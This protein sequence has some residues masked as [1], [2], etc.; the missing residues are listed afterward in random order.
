MA[1]HEIGASIKLEGENKFRNAMKSAENAIKALN[2]E[3]K[4]AKAQF[5]AT[6]D[7][8]AYAAEK[9]R[10]LKEKIEEQKKAV[11]AAE[12]AVKRLT[13]DGVDKNAKIMV[14]WRTKLNNARTALLRMQTSLNGTEAELAEQ[15]TALTTAASDAAA[16]DE[17]LSNIGTQ[18]NFSA[19]ISAIDGMKARLEAVIRTAARAGKAIWEAEVGGGK[20]ADELS[21]KAQ[22]AGMD[23]ET[24]QAWSYA[25]RFIDTSVDD[26]VAS[27]KK[28][29]AALDEPTD[30]ILHDLNSL[31]VSHLDPLTGRARE[32]EAVFWDVVD[33]LGEVES[34]TDKE[35]L[36]MS[37]LG[38]S[39]DN[40]NPLITAGS[41]AYKQLAE[42]GRSVAVVS[43]ENVEAL[44]GFDDANERVDAALLKTKETLLAEVAP[45][46]TQIS[47]SIAEAL[48]AFNAFLE[49]EEGQQALGNLK[50]AMGGIADTIS[51]VDFKKGLEDATG[52]I[53]GLTGGLAWIGDHQEFVVGA[54]EAVG[55]AWA[56]LTVSKDVLT[57]LQ[58]A[59]SAKGL[60]GLTGAASS[61]ST[62]AAA[63]Q[64]ASGGVASLISGVAS[65]PGK[66]VTAVSGLG[67]K[68]SGVAD[69][70][71]KTISAAGQAFGDATGEAGSNFF[72]KATEA[73][74]SFTSAIG[75]GIKSLGTF[76]V[77]ASATLMSTGIAGVAALAGTVHLLGT[78][79][80]ERAVERDY[81][82][83]NMNLADSSIDRPSDNPH[84]QKLIDMNTAFKSAFEYWRSGEYEDDDPSKQMKEAFAQYANELLAEMPDLSFWDRVK[85]MV[86]LSDGLDASEIEKLTD[87]DRSGLI[88][89][90]WL[91][92]GNDVVNGLSAGI[93]DSA[94]EASTAAA[95]MAQGVADATANQLG[96][97]SPSKVTYADGVNVAVGLAN[98][99]Y[100]TAPQAIAAA[101]YLA[102][103]VSNVVRSA[104]D[105]HSPS[106]VAEGLG[107]YFGEG[108]A[109][110]IEDTVS[111]VQDAVSRVVSATTRQPVAAPSAPL[112]R[113]RG[114]GEGQQMLHIT[115]VMDGRTT[116]EAI[117]PY[118]DEGLAQL[119]I[120]RR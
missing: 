13:E 99:I 1:K 60:L 35:Q 2:A 68:L 46:F 29:S 26:I 18:V 63:A 105:I 93:R 56:G 79:L 103:S 89:D 87:P 32:T 31:N 106:R 33:A 95:D 119:S 24:Y 115:L 118:V 11:A 75:S 114:G 41:K 34:Q 111:R 104:L 71:D 62:A 57:F 6:G 83:L 12:T 85:D 91:Q 90:N 48:G 55:I 112:S 16:F 27:R 52:L 43:A 17:N 65:L 5:E 45:A 38:R 7:A 84:T 117:M 19:A 92:L 69:G 59:Q 20:W 4:L 70:M 3:E 42:E 25:S 96:I 10:I 94:T 36:A 116:A 109:I 54:L 37:L 15:S 47:D 108:F 8:E 77:E 107:A 113:G 80:D 78:K 49:T 72:D 51:N 74:H 73:G 76:I 86:N 40:L 110:G 66:A 97:E 102:Q 9:T 101:E 30:E 88:A 82:K 67:D 22:V 39:Y 58:L 14:E 64:T 100:D 44:S 50:T 28:L 53:N 61:I 81:G 98:G 120:Q 21:T 23:V